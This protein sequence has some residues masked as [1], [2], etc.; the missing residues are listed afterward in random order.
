[1]KIRHWYYRH[2]DNDRLLN[3]LSKQVEGE[4]VVI[5]E[6]NM[7]TRVRKEE[8]NAYME[9]KRKRAEAMLKEYEE[10]MKSPECR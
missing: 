1:M 2:F 4:Y 9:L 5:K 10:Y 7:L 3:E 6:G 8:V